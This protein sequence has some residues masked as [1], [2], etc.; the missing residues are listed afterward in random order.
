MATCAAWS[1]PV[2]VL[3]KI[4]VSE[5]GEQ[6]SPHVAPDKTAALAAKASVVVGSSWRANGMANGIMMDMVPKL[7]PVANAIAAL[8]AKTSVG[9]DQLG[10]VGPSVATKN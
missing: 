9:N 8:M 3:D 5:I 1:H 6:W 7:V 4:V 2:P 10:T